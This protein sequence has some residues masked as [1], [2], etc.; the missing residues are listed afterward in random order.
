MSDLTPQENERVQK[1]AYAKSLERGN[2]KKY[3]DEPIATQTEFGTPVR[4]LV[5]AFRNPHL[6][7]FYPYYQRNTKNGKIHGGVLWMYRD[8]EKRIGVRI[9]ELESRFDANKHKVYEVNE[10][11][12]MVCPQVLFVFFKRA[13]ERFVSDVFRGGAVQSHFLENWSRLSPSYGVDG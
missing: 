2:M 8:S 3:F 11:W 9:H 4:E 10:D 12:F 13:I 1:L 6:H 5:W 7:A